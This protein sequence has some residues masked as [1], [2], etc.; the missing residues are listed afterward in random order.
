ML[1]SGQS[2]QL[3]S[4]HNSLSQVQEAALLA[5]AAIGN[6]NAALAAIVFPETDASRRGARP[7]SLPRLLTF[8]F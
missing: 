7:Y 3:V 4:I 6:E 8:Y 5:L 1:S 2:F